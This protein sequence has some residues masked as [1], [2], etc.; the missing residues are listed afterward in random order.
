LNEFAPE[1]PKQF[2]KSVTGN[3]Q[4]INIEMKVLQALFHQ[5]IFGKYRNDIDG[6]INEIKILNE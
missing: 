2:L 6:F 1:D 4:P 5:R 3:S